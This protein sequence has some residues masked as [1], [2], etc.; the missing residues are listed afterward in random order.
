MSDGLTVSTRTP[1]HAS[2]LVVDMVLHCPKCGE[3]HVDRAEPQVR[4]CTGHRTETGACACGY[5]PNPPHRSHLCAHCK[6]VWRP[7]D[8]H[9]NGV[10]SVTTRGKN[11]SLPVR[12]LNALTLRDLVHTWIRTTVPLAGK[13]NLLPS[14]VQRLIDGFLGRSA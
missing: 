2:I 9:T 1:D 6:H 8:A 13:M 12:P 7:S 3:Q 10:E 5:W 14:H 4:A 11:D